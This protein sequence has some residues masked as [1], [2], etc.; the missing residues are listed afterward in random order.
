[1][2]RKF[3]LLLEGPPGSGKTYSLRSIVEA[4]RPLF[5]IATEP[6]IENVLGDLPA[7][8]CHWHYIAPAVPDWD[9]MRRAALAINTQTMKMLVESTGNRSNYQ[10]FIEFVNTCADFTCD[11]TGEAFGPIDAL[12]PEAVVAVD[13][14]SGISI[15]SMDLVAGSKPA[16]SQADWGI[17][18]DN[19]ER[20]ITKLTCDLRCSFVLTAHIEREQDEIT[21]TTKVT[22]STLGKKLAPKI[23]RFFDD[24]IQCIHE[25]KSYYWSNE[26]SGAM[27]KQRLLPTGDKLHPT[28]HQLFR[29]LEQEETNGVA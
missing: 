29:A 8:L 22:V 21:G 18:M 23:P 10:Q 24:V 4:G 5:V 13:S 1:M 9:V 3:N 16:K 19:L 6:G 14:L 26:E 7:E 12:P 2:N 27:L 15:M 17:A 11:R 28:F 25:G 20:M